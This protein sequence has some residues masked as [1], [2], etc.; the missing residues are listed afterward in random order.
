MSGFSTSEQVEN[1]PRQ[2]MLLP[3]GGYRCIVNRCEVKRGKND[4]NTQ[5]VEVEFGFLPYTGTGSNPIAKRKHWE[6]FTIEHS[7]P[8]AVRIGRSQFADFLEACAG[9]E[10]KLTALTQAESACPGKELFVEVYHQKRKDTGETVLRIGGYWHKGGHMRGKEK[11]PLP[12]PSKAYSAQHS[13]EA[14]NYAN[15]ED[16]D[17]PF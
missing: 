1:E 3:P 11:R 13:P 8:E 17:T 9:K 6:R 14:H 15:H 4:I 5:H 2:G 10:V 12:V 7:N 16:E